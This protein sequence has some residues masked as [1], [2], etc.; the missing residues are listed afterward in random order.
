[1][2][3]NPLLLIDFYKA[4][5]RRQYPQGTELVYSNFTP[6]K[7]RVAGT[8][9]M[10][11]FGL[12]Y[13]VKEY[14]IGRFNED[15]FWRA[16]ASVVNEYQQFMERTLGS[17]PG[18]SDHVADLH[19]LGYLP[20]KIKALPEGTRVPLQTPA[21]TMWNTVP[22]FYWLTNYLETLLSA[23]LWKPCTSATTAGDF[24][25]I[26]DHFAEATSDMPEFVDW[27]GHDFSFRGMSGLEDAVMSGAAHLLHF[28][29]TDTVPAIRFLEEYYG[30]DL[31]KELIGGSVPATEHSVMCAGGSEGEMQTLERLLQLYPSGIVS[32]VAD[33][34]DLF[35]LVDDYLPR[36]KDKVMSRDGK[37]VIRPDSGIPNK[38][39]N[40]DPDAGSELERIGVIR[41]LDKHFG[42][43]VNTKGFR[44]LDP[45]VG[46]I[47]GDGI[48]REE[49]LRIFTG[50]QSN[51]YASTNAVI[52]L[53]SYTYE[54]VTRDT[55]GTVCK[56][57]YVEIDGKPQ[58][59]FKDPKT[60]G[61]K[62]SH[63]GLLRVNPDLTTTQNVSWAEEGGMME[64]VF[65]DGK[66]LRE[67]TLQEI[68][69]RV[70]T[71]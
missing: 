6:R 71:Y 27:Q 47:Y 43:T 14:L 53:G 56:A 32:V 61:W 68:R 2:R 3:I 16:K 35:R 64:E 8:N 5:H 33:T 66:L 59:I 12:Q 34:W 49:L 62:K 19:D 57:T 41:L 18:G 54:Y 63:R 69:D 21:L 58:P 42:S 44:Q 24:R 30:A 46:T 4:D 52:G 65:E 50:M 70:R 31:G 10:T 22:E 38:I 29:G 1:M 45:H 25:E 67:H 51:G 28:T 48:N 15:F 39:L 37:L 40:G 60:G 23:V 11:F 55:F 26:F 7:S 13:A 36:L 9:H 20:V 17:F